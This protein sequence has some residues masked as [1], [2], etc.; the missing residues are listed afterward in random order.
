MDT[1]YFAQ[2]D[3]KL[4]PNLTVNLGV[5][6]DYQQ[7]PGPYSRLITAPQTTSHPSDKNNVSARVGFA[8]DPF[9]Q[10]KSVVRGGF[11]TYYGRILNAVIM[12][13]YLNTGSPNGQASY[14]I[15]NGTNIGTTVAPSYLKFPNTATVRPTSSA[16]PSIVYLDPHLQNPYTEQFDLAVQQDL[17]YRNVLSV[18][19]LGALG[20]ELPNYLNVNLDP[21]KYY[22]VT[23]TT[24]AAQQWSLHRGRVRHKVYAT[25]V[26]IPL[27]ERNREYAE[28]KLHRDH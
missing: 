17:G 16:P 20:R 19:Y 3:W 8:Y 14:T 24:A 6:Y 23:Y 22:D 21:T 10:G 2:D 12:N 5:R 11:G 25:C 26:L 13:A 28:P 9:G 15:Y 4:T 7:I 27:R 18:S 1:A